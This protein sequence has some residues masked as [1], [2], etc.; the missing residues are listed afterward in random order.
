MF[1][2]SRAFVL[3]LGLA[4]LGGAALFVAD[5]RLDRRQAWDEATALTLG[6]PAAGQG[7]ATAYGCGSCHEIP[8]VEGATG[9]VGPSLAGFA[10]RRFVAGRLD[11]TPVNVEAWIAHPRR[12]DPQ[13]AMPELG[14]TPG[15]ARDIT[16]YLY[17]LR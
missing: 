14:V 3:V 10:G 16:A 7:K 9:R 1:R 5:T 13:T 2:P 4:A 11:N 17:T 12:I 6:D 15:D 8:G